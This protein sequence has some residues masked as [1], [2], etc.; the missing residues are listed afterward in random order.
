[1]CVVSVQSVL[2]W[3]W[4]ES[5]YH[6]RGGFR[7]GEVRVRE[8]GTQ[9]RVE[10]RSGSAEFPREGEGE[11]T[12]G[13]VGSTSTLARSLAG[14]LFTLAGREPGEGE[15]EGVVRVRRVRRVRVRVSTFVSMKGVVG[16]DC[17][18]GE[19]SRKAKAVA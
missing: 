17:G 4:F 13:V 7:R 11:G 2:S 18:K 10:A 19:T 15:G 3:C 9:L 8:P 5:F 6:I 1:L 12:G 14:W 16:G